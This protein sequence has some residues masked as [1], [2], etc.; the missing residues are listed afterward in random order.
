MKKGKNVLETRS[1]NI[2]DKERAAFA[3]ARRSNVATTG[4]KDANG[5]SGV[6]NAAWDGRAIKRRRR[7]GV[8]SETSSPLF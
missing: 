2:V 3:D 8:S 4:T 5:E 7:R 1:S 6:K